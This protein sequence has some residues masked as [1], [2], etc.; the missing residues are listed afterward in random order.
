MGKKLSVSRGA[1]A[2]PDSTLGFDV[3]IHCQVCRL[4]PC[5]ILLSAQES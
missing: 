4:K 3:N 5:D 2:I 1:L